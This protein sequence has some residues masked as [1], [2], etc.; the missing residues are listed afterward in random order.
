MYTQKF[1]NIKYIKRI[2]MNFP[3]SLN[4]NSFRNSVIPQSH[5]CIIYAIIY[6]KIAIHTIFRY[7]V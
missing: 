5:A 6:S 3:G 4:S 7:L 2:L 1:S